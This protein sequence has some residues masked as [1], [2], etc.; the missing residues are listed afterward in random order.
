MRVLSPIFLDNSIARVDIRPVRVDIK[1]HHKRLSV[2]N[3]RVPNK[4]ASSRLEHPPNLAQS[5]R[6]IFLFHIHKS[7]KRGSVIEGASV[8]FKRGRVHDPLREPIRS[9]LQLLRT[10][11][12]RGDLRLVYSPDDPLAPSADVQNAALNGLIQADRCHHSA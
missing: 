6:M 4:K 5:L 3:N 7:V 9:L 1:L 11:I 12:D 2:L 10:I 8:K